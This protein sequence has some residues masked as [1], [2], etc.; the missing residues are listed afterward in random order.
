M[1]L[2]HFYYQKMTACHGYS[3]GL[4]FG[5]RLIE[6]IVLFNKLPPTFVNEALCSNSV[7]Y[8]MAD[9]VKM[10]MDLG[11]IRRGTERTRD[12]N[13]LSTVDAYALSFSKKKK[14]DVDA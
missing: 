2:S 7:S 8:R 1:N 5:S 6:R 11:C 14:K 3:P 4:L 12:A 10:K 13:L 9:A